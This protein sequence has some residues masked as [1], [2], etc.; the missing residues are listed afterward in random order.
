MS[1]LASLT[2]FWLSTGCAVIA[3]LAV[4]WLSRPARTASGQ[5][6]SVSDLVWAIVPTVALFGILVLTWRAVQS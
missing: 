3:S 2:L 4:V 1:H 5:T 6:H